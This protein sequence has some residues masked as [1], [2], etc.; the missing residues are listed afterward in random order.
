[1]WLA[2]YRAFVTCG[3][4]PH[5][6]VL[7]P[8]EY[9]HC[10]CCIEDSCVPPQVRSYVRNM[11]NNASFSHITQVRSHIQA[12]FRKHRHLTSPALT[13]TQLEKGQRVRTTHLLTKARRDSFC[14][15]QLLDAFEK[16]KQGDE[17]LRSVLQRFERLICARRDHTSMT[18][19]VNDFLVCP[20]FFLSLTPRTTESRSL[21]TTVFSTAPFS[22]PPSLSRPYTTGPFHD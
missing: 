14:Y 19:I 8:T 10:G 21:G 5:F 4:T 6:T 18:R 2:L 20:P 9:P 7:Q 15:D 12:L 11:L 16:A 17:H 22:L 13:R 1:M 3:C